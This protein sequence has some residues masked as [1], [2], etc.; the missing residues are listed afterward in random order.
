MT[1]RIHDLNSS[2]I[3]LASSREDCEGAD[4][5][6]WDMVQITGD[7][8][9]MGKV[10]GEPVASPDLYEIHRC[11]DTFPSPGWEIVM[12]WRGDAY[13]IALCGTYEE[14]SLIHKHLTANPQ[15]CPNTSAAVV[16]SI[17]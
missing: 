6:V 3:Y 1:V 12:N 8:V 13:T 5:H 9:T 15:P 17:A 2:R 7:V 14:A 10:I 4:A 16:D 11:G